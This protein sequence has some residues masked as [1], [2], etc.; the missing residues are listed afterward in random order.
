MPGCCNL[1]TG[2]DVLIGDLMIVELTE[3]DAKKLH[4][5]QRVIWLCHRLGIRHQSG[6]VEKAIS[7]IEVLNHWH[8]P[9]EEYAVAVEQIALY[10]QKGEQH[11]R[12]GESYR[13][14]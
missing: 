14:A 6:D 7:A 2:G 1:P 13:M 12:P 11:E 5:G 3:I 4:P 9:A 10:I 8:L